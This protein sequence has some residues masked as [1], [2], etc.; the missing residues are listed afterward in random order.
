MPDSFFTNLRQ[1]SYTKLQ[2]WMDWTVNIWH[3]IFW[4]Y[5][6]KIAGFWH[7]AS[8]FS[9]ELENLDL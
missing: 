8:M 3:F 9:Y 4:L 6:L 5:H 2:W 1:D 7:T